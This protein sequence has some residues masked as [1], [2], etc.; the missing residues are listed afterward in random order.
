MPQVN[1]PENMDDQLFLL[2]ERDFPLM[3]EDVDK[4][5]QKV[6]N[7]KQEIDLIY[8]S[9]DKNTSLHEE[10]KQ[11]LSDLKIQVNKLTDTQNLPWWRNFQELLILA[12]AIGYMILAGVKA[13][14]GIV[15]KVIPT[16]TVQDQG[17][18]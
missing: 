1:T 12:F 5:S 16:I 11:N 6:D 4:I 9:V 3:R 15:S 18:N 10:T 7:I 8:K 14:E 13:Y 2:I 17:G